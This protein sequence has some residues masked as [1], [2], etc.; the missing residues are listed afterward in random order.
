MTINKE[1]VK[2][3][4]VSKQDISK[5]NRLHEI[6][7]DYIARMK[8]LNP[9]KEQYLLRLFSSFITEINYQLQELWGFD[10]NKNYHRDWYLPHCICP[11][12]DND[13]MYGTDYQVITDKCPIHTQEE[14]ENRNKKISIT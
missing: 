11:K 12:M 8:K 1:L 14:N 10:R 2:K 4:G 5:I 9:K 7:D 13:D 6:R 3:Q